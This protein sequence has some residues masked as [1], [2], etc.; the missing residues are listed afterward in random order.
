MPTITARRIAIW[1]AAALAL[2]LVTSAYLNPQLM[3]D[4]A[5]QLW[6]CF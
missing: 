1:T 3:L 6:A 2:A 5:D 4:L